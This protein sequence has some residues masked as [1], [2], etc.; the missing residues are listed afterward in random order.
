MQRLHGVRTNHI[1]RNRAVVE[2]QRGT[3]HSRDDNGREF[4]DLSR[5]FVRGRRGNA[6]PRD[7]HFIGVQAIAG[8]DIHRSGDIA[9]TD[10]GHA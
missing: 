3:R 10:T 2:G 9:P 4:A 7:A 6:R 5:D 8:E 1:Y